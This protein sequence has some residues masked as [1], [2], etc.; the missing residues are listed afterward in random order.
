M[1]Y[2]RCQT[3]ISKSSWN[4]LYIQYITRSDEITPWLIQHAIHTCTRCPALSEYVSL[5]SSLF[6]SSTTRDACTLVLKKIVSTLTGE[7]LVTFRKIQCIGHTILLLSCHF[8]LIWITR[9]IIMW[10]A[11]VHNFR[12]RR[13]C[14]VWRNYNSTIFSLT[15]NAEN[16]V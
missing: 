8:F 13:P 7:A 11:F 10:N 9:E 2:T 14:S 6:I 15:N 1:H 5:V 4:I 3:S 16:L 12:K